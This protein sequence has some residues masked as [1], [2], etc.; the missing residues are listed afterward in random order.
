MRSIT[1]VGGGLAGCEAALQLAERGF[2]VTLYEMR[3]SVETPAHHGDALAQLVCSNSL[4][5]ELSTTAPGQLKAEL[6]LLGCHLLRIAR[7]CKVPAGSSLAVDRDQF[8]EAVAKA[9]AEHPNIRIVREE[10]TRIPE[11]PCILATGPLT[12]EAL[13]ADLLQQGP[14]LYFF[15]AIAPI[16]NAESLDQSIVYARTRYDKGDPDFLN[17]PFDK[18]QYMAFVEALRAGV[19]HEAHEFESACFHDVRFRFYENCVPIEELA[20]RDEATLRFGVMRPVG[21]IDP[22][23]NRRPWAVLQLRAENT[24]CSAYNLVGCQTMLTYSEQARVFRLIPGLENAEFLRFGSIHRN[25]YLDAPTMLDDRLCLRNKPGVWVAGV[26]SG[27]EGYVESIASG[28]LTARIIA[29]DLPMLPLETILGGLWQALRTAVSDFT[30]RNANFGL[31]PG[32]TGMPKKSRKE[33]YAERAMEKMK[34]YLEGYQ[35]TH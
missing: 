13:T 33:A 23:T 22:R 19:K 27:V 4:K 6:D 34:Q 3:P 21:L 32:I 30:P 16:V 24:D 10:V 25:T 18:D 28:L 20:R 17:C 9:M 26:L 15:D 5:S 31:L 12:S 8:S 35:A 7:E 1:I 29:D 14:G 11:P 2:A